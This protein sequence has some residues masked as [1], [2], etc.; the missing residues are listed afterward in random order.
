[1]CTRRYWSFCSIYFLCSL[2]NKHFFIFMVKPRQKVF[3]GS[4]PDKSYKVLV[5]ENDS[6]AKN[7]MVPSRLAKWRAMK[8]Y[9][10]NHFLHYK[11]RSSAEQTGVEHIIWIATEPADIT[12]YKCLDS[13]AKHRYE[14]YFPTL[15]F[16]SVTVYRIITPNC[17]CILTQSDGYQYWSLGYHNELL[18]WE[19]MRSTGMWFCWCPHYCVRPA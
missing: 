13:Q 2:L 7:S 19:L 14:L 6:R 9:D 11:Q 16:I 8:I 3:R 15:A 18:P 10:R 12:T 5:L 1:M 17:R 4:N